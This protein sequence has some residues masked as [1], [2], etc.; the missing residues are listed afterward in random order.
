MRP[1]LD[2]GNESE[3]LEALRSYGILDA[4]RDEAFDALVRVASSVCEVPIAAITLIDANRQWFLASVGLDVNVRETPREVSFCGHTILGSDLM[5][6]EDTSKDERF[7]DNPLVL[8]TPEREV[9]RG[10]PARR[11]CGLRARNALRPRSRSADAR[12]LPGEGS[13][14]ALERDGPP[15]RG[16]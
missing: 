10:L 14:R 6:I 1:P 16:T 9:L 13:P 4:A 12:S 7:V 8:G 11:P 2:P 5:V 3:R 15:A